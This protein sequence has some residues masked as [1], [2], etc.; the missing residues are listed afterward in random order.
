MSLNTGQ[1]SVQPPDSGNNGVTTSTAP[2]VLG[3]FPMPVATTVVANVTVIARRPDTGASKAWR[4]GMSVQRT[5]AGAVVVMG[6]QNAPAMVAAGDSTPMAGC[7]IAPFSDATTA[8]VQCTG[9]AGVTVNWTVAIDG[10]T[11]TD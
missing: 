8:G 11:L 2:I 6:T 5:G 3:S 1:I 9:P 7:S 4:L 10:W